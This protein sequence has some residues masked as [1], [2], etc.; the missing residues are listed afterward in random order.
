MRTEDNMYVVVGLGN[1]GTRYRSTYHNIG[2]MVADALAKEAR[3]RFTGKECAALTAK[4]KSG[5]ETFVIAKP[6]TYMN[7]SGESVRQLYR[8]Y[9]ADYDELIVVYDDADL[10]VGRMRL[11][12]EGSAGTHNG[13]RS[14]VAELNTTS[15]KRLRIGIKTEELAAKEVEIVDLVLSKVDYADKPA[16]ER[17]IDEGADAILRLIAGEDIQRIEERLNRRK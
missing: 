16:I 4:A 15:F 9:C 3:V 2:F 17:C 10:P 6:Q 1:P 12:E 14:I 5:G 8:K 13:M 11:R 7:N